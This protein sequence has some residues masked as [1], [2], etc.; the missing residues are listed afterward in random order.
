MTDTPTT[1]WQQAEG[2]ASGRLNPVEL[3]ETAL[4]KATQS[5][6]VFIAILSERAR[7]E[8]EQSR[9]RQQAGQRLSPIDGVPIAWKDLVDMAGTVTTAGSQLYDTPATQDAEAV[10]LAT[11]AGLVSVGKVNM[12]ELAYSGLG[13][14]P[15]YGTPTLKR[16][17]PA[18]VPGGSSSGSAMAVAQGIVTAAIGSD[19]AG[20]LRIPAAFNGLVSYRPSM[21]RPKMGGVHPLS[22]SMDTLGVLARTLADVL[23]VDDAMRLGR[24]EH[25]AP[26]AASEIR[27][28]LDTDALADPFISEPVRANLLAAAERF[29]AA[30]VRVIR[31]P[32]AAIQDALAAIA[33][34]GWL[35]GMEAYTE[36]KDLIES[37]PAGDFDPRVR[38]R[39]LTV[40]DAGPDRVIRL[41]RAR[42]QLLLDL[43]AQ[44]DGALLISP[45]VANVA[46]ELAPLLSD[47]ALYA[48]VNLEALRLTMAASLLTC[49]AVALPTGT[50][51]G[52]LPTSVQLTALPGGDERLLRTA[53][54]LETLAAG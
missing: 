34:N 32:V 7:F 37:R 45:T 42:Q 25:R 28:I 44:L 47:D 54:T 8:A 11:Q 43:A 10:R 16:S 39:L 26:V 18:R 9:A 17:G 53:L 21:D 4:A 6:S 19:T 41:Y 2:I 22:R 49:P 23:A 35:G 20:S 3:T 29:E 36:Y 13:L 15:H 52:G 31:R 38:D 14:N 27:V 40:K 12:T 48:K 5:E 1:L 46:P 50:D 33:S 24:V 51:A 30:G